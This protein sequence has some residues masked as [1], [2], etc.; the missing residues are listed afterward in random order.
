MKYR[1]SIFPSK[2]IQDTANSYRKRYDPKY[3]LIPPHITLKA[4]FEADKVK[5]KELITELRNI[6]AKTK[7]FQINIHK[8]S[9]FAP[10]TNTIYFKV[11]PI[12]ELTDLFEKMHSG[13]FPTESEH[14]FATY[15]NCTE[16]V[17]WRI[18]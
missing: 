1:I 10:V 2:E 6:A 8:V 9:T 7:P 11:E 3:A 12:Q 17:R 13:K 18:L 5:I 14:A 4:A 15:Y 16:I